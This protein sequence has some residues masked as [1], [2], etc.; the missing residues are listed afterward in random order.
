MTILEFST[1]FTIL[2]CQE[3][4]TY[5]PLFLLGGKNNMI[6]KSVPFW[7]TLETLVVNVLKSIL[8]PFG[9]S[10]NKVP[11]C[12]THKQIDGF[13]SNQVASSH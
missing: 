9:V 3:V 6:S 10:V 11:F 5:F 7:K 12:N 8:Y 13:L 1:S 4:N 2:S